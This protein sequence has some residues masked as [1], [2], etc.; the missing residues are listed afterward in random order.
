MVYVRDVASVR[1]GN[2]PQ[3]NIVHVDGNR[4]VLMMVLKNG[5]I[6]TLDIIAGHQAEGAVEVK[7]TLPDA[8]KIAL[9]GDQSLFVRGAING[10]AQEGV[11]AALL[12]SVMILLFLGSWRSTVII[13][14]SIPLVRARRDRDAV[15]DRRDAQH[16]DAG[17]PR[18][19][20]RHPGRRRH[21][22]DREHQLAS[23]AGQGGRDRDPGRRQRR[24]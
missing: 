7:A 18:A 17:R 3:T 14:I 12:T 10:V 11:I 15:G 9:I 19:G 8:L 1:D 16:H 6:S 24:S 13:A 21:G 23:R 5:S 20:G 22:D 2:P 4:S